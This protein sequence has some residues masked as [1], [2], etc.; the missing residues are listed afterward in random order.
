MLLLDMYLCFDDL[1]D[2]FD[3]C[4]LDANSSPRF[5][6]LHCVSVAYIV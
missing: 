4:G 1:L 6:C 5:S 2:S 3:G